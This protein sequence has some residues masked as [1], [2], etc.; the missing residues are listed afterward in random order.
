MNKLFLTFILTFCSFPVLAIDCPEFETALE[1]VLKRVMARE[2]VKA[3]AAKSTALSSEKVAAFKKANEVEFSLPKDS[4]R[5]Y[6]AQMERDAAMKGKSRALYFDVENSVQKKLNDA[7]FGEKTMVDAVNNSFMKRFHS[8]VARNPELMKRMSGQYKDYKS[9]RLRLELK[10]GDEAEKFTAMLNKAYKDAVDGFVAEYKSLD[11]H[12]LTAGRTDDVANPERW[13]L[14]GVGDDALEANMAARGARSVS[15]EKAREGNL[16]KYQE[17]VDVMSRDVREIEMLRQT[18]AKNPELLSVGI[19]DKLENGAMIPSKEMINILRKYK[20]GDFKNESL[21]FEAIRKKV[22]TIFGKE[23]S[24]E[25][26]MTLTNFQKKVDAISPPL[27]SRER[28]II[29]LS[30]ADDGIV[31]VDFAGVGVD[32]LYQQM[33][34]LAQ[35]DYK[36]ADKVLLLKDAFNRLQTNVDQVT[37][38]MNTAKRYFTT[39]VQKQNGKEA[40]PLFSGDDGIYMPKGAEWK[41]GDKVSLVRSLAESPDPS[42]YRV[43]FVKSKYPD[44]T[45]IPTETRSKLIVKAEGLEKKIR[46][47]MVAI[48]RFSYQDSK[49]IIT[50]ID[51]TPSKTGGGSFNIIVAGKKLKPEEQKL[52]EEIIKK[53]IKT[54]EGESFGRIIY[55][56]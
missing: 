44:G 18:L 19:L 15:A 5:N 34:A 38:D 52:L 23:I 10:E 43:T 33:K 36:E 37:T 27:F 46:E 16:L 48:D 45:A 9:L 20:L 1:S 28:T 40:R 50:A 35:V 11:L 31:S 30:K 54:N 39:S 2:E 25:S 14:A 51:F 24:D 29:D 6:M 7:I 47:E 21:Y 49:K 55:P 41:E 22:K 8:E 3:S 4:N 12:A 17:H 42:K 32:N 26:I 53:N 56:E 13:F